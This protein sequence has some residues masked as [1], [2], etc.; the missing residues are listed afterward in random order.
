MSFYQ[1]K[2]PFTKLVAG[3]TGAGKTDYIE[4]LLNNINNL[5]DYPPEE[6]IFCFGEWQPTYERLNTSTQNIRFV[7]GLPSSEQLTNNHRKL[8]IIDDLM[9]E[10]DGRITNIF[11]KGSHHRNLSVVYIVQN[12]F[13]KNKEHRTITLNCHYIV[14][15]KNPRDS[16]QIVRLASQIYPKNTRFMLDAYKMATTEPYSYLFLDFKQDTP[17]HLRLRSHI[18]PSETQHVYIPK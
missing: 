13:S 7:E 4:R 15:F 1:L 18:F 12:V 11:T 8:L 17:E 5:V 10:I 3:P 16:S 2:H 9:Q 6:I 14:I